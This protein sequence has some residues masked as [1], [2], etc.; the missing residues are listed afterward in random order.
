MQMVWNIA[1]PPS[2]TP[3]AASHVPYDPLLRPSRFCTAS[4]SSLPLFP[5]GFFAPPSPGNNPHSDLPS[6][7]AYFTT[8]S[9]PLFSSEGGGAKKEPDKKSSGQ[10]VVVL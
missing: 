8:A 7:S 1:R 9:N 10:E 4:P 5:Y 3:S 2:L 6:A